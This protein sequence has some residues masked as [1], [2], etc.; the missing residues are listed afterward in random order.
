MPPHRSP[1]W[2]VQGGPPAPVLADAAVAGALSL[3]VSWAAVPG[4]ATYVLDMAACGPVPA[5]A[6]DSAAVGRLVAAQQVA[7]GRAYA[8][9]ACS[10]TVENLT[11]HS[12]S[13]KSPRLVGH[14][15]VLSGCLKSP[16]YVGHHSPVSLLVILVCVQH[17]V[18]CWSTNGGLVVSCSATPSACRPWTGTGR[19]ATGAPSGSSPP[20]G[21]SR[22]SLRRRLT[23]TGRC[24][25]SRHG[26]VRQPPRRRPRGRLLVCR[27]EWGAGH[28]SAAPASDCVAFLHK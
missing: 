17:S 7:F 23:R 20:D 21:T 12:V 14:R 13:G 15:S 18:S 10:P 6:M 19:R 5:V 4:A 28:L 16:L 24:T 26:A 27:S 2:R 22:S 25:T 8:G 11:R 3:G 1:S 9:P